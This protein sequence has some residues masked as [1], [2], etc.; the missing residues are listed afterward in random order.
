[1]LIESINKC[2]KKILLYC[3][4]YAYPF[5]LDGFDVDFILLRLYSVI[6]IQ[7]LYH[8]PT[9]HFEKFHKSHAYFL[10]QNTIHRGELGSIRKSRPQFSVDSSGC[11]TPLFRGNMGHETLGA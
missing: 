7:Q 6:D 8:R 9:D 5:Q 10:I 11:S 2:V 3:E 1:M 4:C